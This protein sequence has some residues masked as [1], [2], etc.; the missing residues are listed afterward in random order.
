VLTDNGQQFTARF[1]GGGEVLFDKI[2]RG[3]GITH[4]LTQPRSPTTTG[5]IERFHQTLRRELLDDAGPF[6]SSLAAQ[7]ALDDWVCEYNATRPDQALETRAPVTPAQRF[8]PVPADERELLPLWLPGAPPADAADATRPAEVAS[9]NGAIRMSEAAEFE[10][11]IPASGNL[12]VM[13]RQF[14]L[15]P[16]RRADRAV[17]G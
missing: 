9:N 17:L 15:G 13:G 7:A 14:W 10:R 12:W 16:A 11:V 3:N 4:R 5:K 8:Q 6:A 2:C 1:S